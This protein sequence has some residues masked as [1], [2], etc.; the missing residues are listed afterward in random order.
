MTD[1][2]EVP[3]AGG[4]AN[5][6]TRRGDTVRRNAGP[7]TPVVHLLLRHLRAAGFSLAPQPIGLDEQGREV[8]DYLEGQVAWWPWPDVLRRNDGLR[9]VTSM[10]RELSR[11]IA[12]FDEPP[13]AIWHGGP[14]TAADLVIRHGDLAP[15]NTLWVG[16]RLTGLIDWDTAEPAPSGWD[17]AQAAWYFLPLRPL[18]G[19]RTAGGGFTVDDVGH[20]LALWCDELDLDPE[21][22]LDL[23]AQVQAFERERILTRGGAGD[24]PYATFLTRGDPVEIDQDRA[25]LTSH[26]TG[27]LRLHAREQGRH[28]QG[29]RG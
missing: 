6:V 3:L 11:A 2:A 20:R 8:L 26:R 27:L 19:Y 28:R 9:A 22:L 13:D 16:D 29:D 10:I 5:V 18:T 25:W 24:E 4:F 21:E 7:W 1:D 17:A 12:T 14:R 15:W 23:V